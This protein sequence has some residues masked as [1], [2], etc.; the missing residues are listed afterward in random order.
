[1]RGWRNLLA[2]YQA[3]CFV[4][5]P[6]KRHRHGTGTG[7]SRIVYFTPLSGAGFTNFGSTL[8]PGAGRFL[9]PSRRQGERG[10]LE[11]GSWK[12]AFGSFLSHPHLFGGE[13]P[14]VSP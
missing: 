13:R 4:L 11:I 9:S 6:A 8:R 10:L 5:P 12:L 3:S 2:S 1:M 14:L 7:S